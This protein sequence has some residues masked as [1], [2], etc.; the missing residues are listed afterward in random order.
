MRNLRA[1]V[2][3]EVLEDAVDWLGFHSLLISYTISGLPAQ[4]RY[5]PQLIGPSHINH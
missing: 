4:G 5:C 1:V 3:V 2:D